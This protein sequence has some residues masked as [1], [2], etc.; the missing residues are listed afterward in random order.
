MSVNRVSFQG[1]TYLSGF[2]PNA[3]GNNNR[4][5][6]SYSDCHA[7]PAITGD[8][9]AEIIP[10]NTCDPNLIS[11]KSVDPGPRAVSKAS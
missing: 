5:N 8:D 2:P 4:D 1:I 10:Q 9:S 6:R 3:C 11:W 7:R